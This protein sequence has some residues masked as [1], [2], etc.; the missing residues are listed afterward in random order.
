MKRFIDL[1]GSEIFYNF[2]WWD[3][4]IDRFLDFGGEWA[5]STIDEFTYSFKMDDV[6]NDG[7]IERYLGLIP[8]W[9]PEKEE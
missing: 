8:G 4:I 9:V 1:R 7:D 6:Y 3:T 2:A 5:W